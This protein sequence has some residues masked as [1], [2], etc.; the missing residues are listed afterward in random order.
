MSGDGG[1]VAVF[2]YKLDHLPFGFAVFSPFWFRERGKWKT[3]KLTS[4]S[5]FTKPRS[6]MARPSSFAR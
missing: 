1:V 6:S 2:G 4:S 3:E 5:T